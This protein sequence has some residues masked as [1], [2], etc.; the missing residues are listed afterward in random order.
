M[1]NKKRFRRAVKR[2]MLL[3]SVTAALFTGVVAFIGMTNCM[4]MDRYFW[5]EMA[6]FLVCAAYVFLFM[7]ANGEFIDEAMKEA[8]YEENGDDYID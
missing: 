6:I 8:Y 5:I 7:Y 1:R 3:I 4:E 2:T